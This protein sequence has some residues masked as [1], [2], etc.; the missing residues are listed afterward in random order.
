[1][2]SE[3][4]R[5]ESCTAAKRFADASIDACYVDGN[6]TKDPVALDLRAWWHALRVGGFCILDDIEWDGVRRAAQDFAVQVDT[7]LILVSTGNREKK[8]G[9]I[10]KGN[11]RVSPSRH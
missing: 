4:L 11:S 2:R 10:I 6:H 1:M 8:W 7:E 9:L 5:E 3:L